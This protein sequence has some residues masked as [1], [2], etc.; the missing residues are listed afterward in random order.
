[1]I[2]CRAREAMPST[3][4]CAALGTVK[5]LNDWAAGNPGPLAIRAPSPQEMS[6]NDDTGAGM[7]YHG[8]IHPDHVARGK[9][10]SRPDHYKRPGR[11]RGVGS[12]HDSRCGRGRHALGTARVSRKNSWL[13]SNRSARGECHACRPGA[14]REGTPFGTPICVDRR[15][16]DVQMVQG[17]TWGNGRDAAI[18]RNRIAYCRTWVSFA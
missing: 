3:A 14:R 9:T 10:C 13:R 8:Y 12:V 6:K 18:R 11:H 4:S 2:G 17:G 1:M 16:S 7:R 5:A 15:Q